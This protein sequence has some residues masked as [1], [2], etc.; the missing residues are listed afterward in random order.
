MAKV[1]SHS[2]NLFEV[3]TPVAVSAV[4]GTEMQVEADSIETRIIMLEHE[5]DIS[6]P[7]GSQSLILQEL[8]GVVVTAAGIGEPFPV[9]PNETENWWEQI[10]ISVASPVNLFVTDPLG[11]HIGCSPTGEVVNEIPGALYSG[12][13]VVPEEITIP[14]PCSGDYDIE[15]IPVGTGDYH[16]TVAGLGLGEETFRNEYSGSVEASGDPVHIEEGFEPEEQFL[17]VEID[18]KPGYFPNDLNPRKKGRMPVAILTDEEFDAANVDWTTVLFGALGSEAAPV[19]HALEDVD[20][21][22]DIDLILHFKTKDT[23]LQCG[24]TSAYLTGWTL[25]T[26]EFKGYDSVNTIGCGK[27]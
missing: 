23:D 13:T 1:R 10:V 15:L 5:A 9:A 17:Q 21:D 18:I 6:T 11:R 7:D 24:D 25:D 3:S 14:G 22:G 27:K 16:L 2:G 19:H 4:R 20:A 8:Q 26:K 12:P